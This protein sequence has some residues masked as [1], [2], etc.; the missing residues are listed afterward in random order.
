LVLNEGLVPALNLLEVGSRQ[1]GQPRDRHIRLRC[2]S[3]KQRLV[4]L[5]PPANRGFIE[6]PRIVVAIKC[7]AV[8]RFHNIEKDIEVHKAL[9]IRI[10]VGFKP[11]QVKSSSNTLQVELYF[12]EG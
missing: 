4:V 7:Q 9:W 1:H 8:L 12:G 6:E 10:D 11:D 5:Q 3:Y 2:H